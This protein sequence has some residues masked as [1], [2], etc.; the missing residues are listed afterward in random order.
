MVE[1]AMVLPILIL[2]AFSLILVMV[3]YYENH[4]GQIA[5]H[6]EMLVQV[7]ESNSL[8]RIRKRTQEHQTKLDGMVNHILKEEKQHQIYDL[9]PAAWIR[10]GE[11]AGLEDG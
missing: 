2:V 11:M 7:Q 3:H 9:Q 1:A 10:L 8:F 4:H 6:K 5:L